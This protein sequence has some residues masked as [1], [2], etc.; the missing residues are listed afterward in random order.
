MTEHIERNPPPVETVLGGDDW[1]GFLAAVRSGDWAQSISLAKRMIRAKPADVDLRI[2]IARQFRSRWEDDGI[3]QV[4]TIC[5]EVDAE[6]E[7]RARAKAE[8][9]AAE[10]AKAAPKVVRLSAFARER[11]ERHARMAAA[12]RAEA[13]EEPDIGS[14]AQFA[15]AVTAQVQKFKPLAEPEPEPEPDAGVGAEPAPDEAWDEPEPQAE[16]EPELVLSAKTPM[17]TAREFAQRR[18]RQ[19]GFLATYFYKDDFWK[20]NGCHYRAIGE[21][22][23]NAEIYAFLDGAKVVGVGNELTRFQLK[24]SDAEAVLKCLKAGL[25]VGLTA[26][27]RWLDSGKPAPS[28]IAFRNRLVD[29]ETGEVSALTPKL[30]IM[31]GVNFDFD[32]HARCPRWEQFLEEVFPNDPESQDC[33]EEQLGY[34]MTTDMRFEKGALWI[35]K[36][37]SGKSTIAFVLKSLVG[38][39]SHIGLSFHTWL[40]SENSGS[41]MIGK[42]A[43]VF[44]DVRLK[45]S[46]HYGKVG[47]DP[48]GIDHVSA[49]QLLKIIGRDTVSL[50]EKYERRPWEGELWIK[51]Y[52]LSNEVPNLQDAGGVLQSRFIKLDFKQTFWGREDPNLRAKLTAELPGIANRCLAAYRRLCAR[53]GFIQPSAGLE[54]ERKIEARVNPYAAFMQGWVKDGS[55]SGPTVG[56]FYSAFETWCMMTDREYLLGKT[57]RQLLIQRINELDEWAW[58]KSSKVHDKPRRYAGI[59]RKPREDAEQN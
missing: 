56:E 14:T 22:E 7:A 55:A 33:I 43:G 44:A 3:D 58:L 54:L 38:E 26:T 41:A 57:P 11:A 46:V 37:R 20:W 32:R 15:G 52:I 2:D 34:G 10:A 17:L 48:G 19:Q 18:C 30:W 5:D 42:K 29:Y 31:D 59:K 45:P 9:E 50:G 12:Q 39:R 53:G 6:E 36:K 21:A 13:A 27:Q 4:K 16:P 35:G 24:P 47:F 25:V 40:K 49:E 8:A 23:I 1:S 28:L 51:F